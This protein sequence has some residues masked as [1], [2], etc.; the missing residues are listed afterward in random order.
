MHKDKLQHHLEHLKEKHA[1]LDDQIDK[2]ES[3]GVFQ[4]FQPNEMKKQR[5]LIK[6]EM[7]ITEQ[8]IAGCA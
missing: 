1:K 5:L 6:D 7:S 2:M 3:S 8:K 4:D